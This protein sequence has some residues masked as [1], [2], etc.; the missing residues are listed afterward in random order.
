[1]I[2]GIGGAL[3]TGP[4]VVDVEGWPALHSED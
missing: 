1:V 4:V 2:R 3:L